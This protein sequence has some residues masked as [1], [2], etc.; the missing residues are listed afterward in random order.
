M[1]A[2]P[3]RASRL[4]FD[5]PQPH[6]RKC[7]RALLAVVGGLT[8]WVGVWDVLDYHLIPAISGECARAEAET[9]G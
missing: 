4:F 2:P 3:T 1:P 6:A 7:G 9:R 5:A 8:F